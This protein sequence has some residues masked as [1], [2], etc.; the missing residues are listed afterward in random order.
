[1]NNQQSQ[2]RRRR[3]IAAWT[4]GILLLAGSIFSAFAFEGLSLRAGSVATATATNPASGARA[5]LVTNAPVS[6]ADLVSQTAPAVV[7]INAERRVREPQQFPFFDNPFFNE[8]FGQDGRRGMPREPN[9]GDAP[10]QMALGSG[11]IVTPDGYLLTNHHVV[12]GA[13]KIKVELTD[14]HTYEAK[15]VGSDPA[16]DL[17]LLKINA[18]N[19]PVL[20]LGDSDKARVGDVVLAIGNPMGVGQTV[21]MGIVSAK[22]RATGLGDGSFEDFIQTDAPINQGNSGGA[23]IDTQ[24]ELIGINSQIVSPS[25]GNIG[26]GFAI[27]SNMARSVMDQLLKGGKVHRGLLGVTVQAMNSDLAATLGL[28]EVRGALVSQVNSG[29]AA[30]KAG[31]KRGDVITAI[32]GAPVNDSNSLRNQVARTQPGSEVTLTILRDGRE[33]QL[34]ATLTEL[35][36]GNG[37]GEEV[38]A[39]DGGSKGKFGLGVETLT[40]E[41]AGQL[42]LKSDT[43]GLA[44]MSVD[45]S[46]PAAEAGIQSGDVI[47]EVNRQSVKSVDELK[48]VLDRNGDKPSLVL[49]SR[50]GT[51]LYLTLR[52]RQ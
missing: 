12:D 49:I 32:N 11:V 37:K 52:P 2:N 18:R 22:G 38:G 13:E 15:V 45:P 3:L 24:G 23:L 26:I 1:M 43:K 17:A 4:I 16:S 34:K 29:S 46:G 25:G 5:N 35:K 39:E 14:K 51:T 36:A 8:F 42:G 41:L 27:P 6:Y 40:P 33:Q 47:Q 21:T 30:E 50:K 10:R 19:L 9:N 7:T 28:S 48:A 20:P 44:V 31:I